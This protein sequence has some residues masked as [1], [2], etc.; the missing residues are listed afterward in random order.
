MKDLPHSLSK[1]LEK[2]LN[3]WV[4][5]NKSLPEE[6][7]YGLYNSESRGKNTNGSYLIYLPPSYTIDSS[8][9][10]PTLYWLHG[11]NGTQREGIWAI[12][13]YD[14][15]IKDGVMPEFIIVS[16]Q[17]LPVGRYIDSFDGTQPIESVII[18]N[19]IPHID[20]TYRTITK[21]EDRYIEGMSMGGYGA[22]RFGFKYPDLFGAISAVA[23]SILR[24]LSEEHEE[25]G[26]SYNYDQNYFEEIGPWN[27]VK[28]KSEQFVKNS[29]RLRLLVG[30]ND[31][32]LLPT[33]RQYH[34][35]LNNLN[36]SH[37]YDEVPN[38][39]H[40]YSEIITGYGNKTFNFWKILYPD[41]SS[42]KS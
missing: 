16:P 12:Q 29:N 10:F 33:I 13:R 9:R 21:R 7:T 30:T 31:I 2:K 26:R 34:E 15:A 8:T 28:V 32:R 35:L 37:E 19:L 4:D 38:A 17:A 23:P 36:I 39:A 1:T 22:L 6:V 25:V 41:K 3:E 27:L 40:T 18:K 42:F 5:P 11:G 20:K 14:K 24:N